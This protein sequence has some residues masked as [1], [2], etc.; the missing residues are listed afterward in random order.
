MEAEMRLWMQYLKGFYESKM[1]M[2]T[3]ESHPALADFFK[4]LEESDDNHR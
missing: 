1:G 4:R 3:E 2:I